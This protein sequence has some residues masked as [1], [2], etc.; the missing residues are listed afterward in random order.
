MITTSQPDPLRKLA[1]ALN[2]GPLVYRTY[3]Q[4]RA[5]LKECHRKGV[6]NMA[7]DYWSRQQMEA[8]A[9]RLPLGAIDDAEPTFDIYFLSGRKFWYQTCFCAYSMTR[10][11]NINLRPVIYDD[12]TLAQE[13]IDEIQR[14]FPN[15]KIVSTAEIAEQLDQYLP[16]SRFPY[17]RERRTNYPNIR[18]LTD[19]HVGAHGWKLVLDSDMLFFAAPQFLLDWL[20]NS[21]HPCH[22]V[23][24]KTSYG[25]PLELMASLAGGAIAERLN[26]GICGLQSEAIDWEQL[27]YWCKTLIEQH[28][29][30][31]YQ[32]QA[33]IAMLM[34][35]QTPQAAPEKDYIALPEQS[36][37]IQPQ[38]VLHHY[39]ADSKSWYFRYGWRHCQDKVI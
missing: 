3:H 16:V 7:I 27:E 14:I 18:K 26:V 6:N 19:V 1:K 23:D 10:N 39:V 28:G 4:P 32:E 12:G 38:A 8:A 33:L 34:A 30:H 36:E 13:Y 24:T 5:F 17:L 9:Y 31:Y 22:M 11:S 29:T 25:Y 35:T 37:V 21:Q 15:A 20:E 2:L